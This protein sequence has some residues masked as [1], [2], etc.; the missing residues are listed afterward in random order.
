MGKHQ[1]EQDYLDRVKVRL[2]E[3]DELERFNAL[4]VERHYLHSAD[5]GG[6]TLRYVAEVGTEWVGIL[7]FGSAA[8]H[9][10]HRE[11]E[12]GWSARQR[13]RRLNLI[14]NNRRFLMLTP[15]Q[16]YPNLASKVLGLVLRRLSL[17]YEAKWNHPVVGVETFVDETLYEGTCYRACG[18]KVLGQTAGYGRKNG[19]F[20]L[21]HDRPKGIYWKELDVKGVKALSLKT[22][23]V[24]YESAELTKAGKSP[25]QAK[26]YKSL[27]ELFATF[28]DCRSKGHGMLYST[29]SIL[30]CAAV[31]TLMGAGCFSAME[32]ICARFDQRVL[33]MLRC[34][35]SKKTGRHQ[36]PSDS[37]F[38]KVLN[39]IDAT[40]FTHR[41]GQWLLDQNP[42][43][44]KSL[45]IDGKTLRGS[46]RDDG[47]SLHLLTAVTHQLSLALAQKPVGEKTNEIPEAIPLLKSI[48]SIEGSLLTLDAMHTQQETARFITQDLG[49][50]YLLPIKGNQPHLQ[51]KAD[52]LFESGFFPSA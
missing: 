30:A 6:Q 26:H 46:G 33:R 37:T 34:G 20:Y 25:F 23:P 16:Q 8:F 41:V 22:L 40:E 1:E 21:Q 4:L 10:K 28:K 29:R 43:L 47:V 50:D 52:R 49:A 18:F 14:V 27:F 45:S 17:D 24:K 19:D 35:R 38:R 39:S 31:A 13:E 7:L 15:R 9:L 12:I 2:L 44:L 3:G 5:T 11:K 51:E 36:S 32:S 48:P 42:D